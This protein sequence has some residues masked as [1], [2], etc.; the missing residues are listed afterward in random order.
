MLQKPTLSIIIPIYNGENYIHN[1]L[2][3]ISS[4]TFVNFEVILVDDGSID[5][6][7]TICDYYAKKDKRIKVIHKHN[8][9]VSLARIDGANISNG[10]YIAF[11]DVDDYISKD[12]IQILLD[13]ITKNDSDISMC[14]YYDVRNG[15]LNY[16]KRKNIGIYNREQIESLLKEN[17][18]YDKECGCSG[19]PLFLWGKI[20]KRSIILSALDKGVGFKYGEDMIINFD[21]LFNHANIISVIPDC[22]YYYVHH[23]QQ[24]TQKPIEVLWEQYTK[25]WEH[26]QKADT[27]GY[28]KEQLPN[29]I[30]A[31]IY[32]SLYRVLKT[33]LSYK[34]FQKHISCFR[35]TEIIKD[36]I[37][38]RNLNESF[39]H[40]KLYTLLKY[41]L[42]IIAYLY[43][44]YINGYLN[45]NKLFHQQ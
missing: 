44:L 19:L 9:G 37:F 7:G 13:S 6:S 16:L 15:K 38:N 20:Y 40:N 24:A 2:R 12:Y 30:M 23:T 18:L 1:C 39:Q 11:I 42:Y 21:I 41:K 32:S 5:N 34:H 3:S 27:K 31:F 26:I 35:N 33:S 14:Q 29:R 17:V 10:D 4:Q 36:V 22:L 25:L 45:T 8:E 43:C 28:F